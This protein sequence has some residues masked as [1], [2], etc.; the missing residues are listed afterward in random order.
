[1]QSPGLYFPASPFYPYFVNHKFLLQQIATGSSKNP[2]VGSMEKWAMYWLY[3]SVR[4]LN[5]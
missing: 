5:Y 3:Y 4:L 2:R 1:M